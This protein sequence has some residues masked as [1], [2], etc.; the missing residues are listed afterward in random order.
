MVKKT[1]RIGCRGCGFDGR[2]VLDTE[3]T[4]AIELVK[5]HARATI[6]TV[7]VEDCLHSV[8]GNTQ[9]KGCNAGN[10]NRSL[11]PACLMSFV[12]FPDD[13]LADS[14]GWCDVEELRNPIFDMLGYCQ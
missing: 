5:P 1:K 9:H 11:V 3:V 14:K 8:E 13:V 4:V 6:V 10:P 2:P 12:Q 7:H